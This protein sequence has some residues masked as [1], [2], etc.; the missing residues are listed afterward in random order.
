MDS[1]SVRRMFRKI[2][3][4]VLAALSVAGTIATGYFAA[5]AGAESVDILREAEEQK[6]DPLTVKEKIQAV[7][8]NYIPAL[9]CG[10]ATIASIAGGYAIGRR[11]NLGLSAGYMALEKK[12]KAYKEGVKEEY[13]EEAHAKILEKMALPG[14]EKAK[15]VS[16]T[17]ECLG[18]VCDLDFQADEEER[19]FYDVWSGKYF[20]STI[21]RVMAAEQ[22]LNRNFSIGG[23]AF[24]EDWYKFL[25]I[26]A[27]PEAKQDFLGWTVEDEL[28]W[29]DFIH[30]RT[31][32]DDGFE[33]Y[34][35]EFAWEPYPNMY[36]KEQYH[37][38][39]ENA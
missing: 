23:E 16:L 33:A 12:Y 27:P 5:K 32:T 14:I 20:I 17:G 34:V 11:I 15:E 30:Y 38:R 18:A 37:Y 8:K 13:G 26:E 24:L 2:A 25:G 36:L 4:P 7:G 6:G 10:A 19:T 35:I 22:H 29:I 39:G 21:N 1:R 28:C 9:A 3:P 31:K